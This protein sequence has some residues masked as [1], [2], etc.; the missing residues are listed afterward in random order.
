MCLCP[1]QLATRSSQLATL[2][3]RP[4]NEEAQVGCARLRILRTLAC[5]SAK[6]SPQRPSHSPLTPLGTCAFQGAQCLITLRTSY[7]AGLVKRRGPG[8]SSISYPGLR[9][10]PGG[11]ATRPISLCDGDGF[12]ISGST[13]APGRRVPRCA[14]SLPSMFIRRPNHMTPGEH[15]NSVHPP[16]LERRG[17]KRKLSS[18]AAWATRAGWY[19]CLSRSIA[20]AITNK[21]RITATI[22]VFER[23]LQPR[24]T[25]S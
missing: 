6:T 20:Q 17:K 21:R 12:L 19:G 7:E 24:R 4:N 22:A 13:P 2:V 1:A 23:A 25:R 8:M 11:P 16:M 10:R 3:Q 9:V 18:Y 14:T 15:G 5:R